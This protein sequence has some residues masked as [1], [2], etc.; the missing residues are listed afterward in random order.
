MMVLGVAVEGGLILVALLAGWLLGQ[1]P[2]Q[3]FTWDIEA[4]LLGLAATLPMLLLFFACLRWP[5]GP[6]KPIQQFCE[7]V[8]VPLLA[9]CTLF[10][11]AL[12]SILAGVGEEMLFRGVAQEA[13]KEWTGSIVLGLLL[14]SVLF[15]L[16]HAITAGYVVLA[17]LLGAYLGGLW[18]HTGNLLAPI[19][20]HA[21]YDFVALVVLVGF[22]NDSAGRVSDDVR[23]VADA[24]GSD[25]ASKSHPNSN[26]TL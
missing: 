18:L 10:D 20:A 4:A 13:L 5:I 22:R 15:G 25:G 3:T 19:V 17:T 8:L 6:L 11:L 23:T 24:S 14:A 9:P 16:C 26:N 12:I 21:V 7:E 1:P 2:F